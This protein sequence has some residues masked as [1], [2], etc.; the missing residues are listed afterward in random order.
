MKRLL[1]L[2]SVLFFINYD[3]FAQLPAITGTPIA[4]AGSTSALSNGTPG[5]VWTS[6]TPAIATVNMFTGVVTGVS[7]GTTTITYTVGVSNVTTTFLVNPLPA[8]ITGVTTVC[9][10]DWTSLASPGG[11]LWTSSNPAVA[12][13]GSLSGRVTSTAAG[14]TNI[15]Y[16][17]STGCTT[18]VPVTVNPLPAPIG[19]NNIVYT[20]LTLLLSDATAGGTWSSELPS[21][22]TVHPT[23]GLVTGA[24]P[25]GVVSI[26]YTLPTGCRATKR[27]NVN[28]LPST[29]PLGGL[30]GWYPFCNDTT[31][32]SGNTRH[33]LNSNPSTIPATPTTDRFGI[34]NSAFEFNGINTMMNYTTFFPNSGITGDFSYSCWINAYSNQSSVIIYNGRN[35]VNGFGF[36]MNNGTIGT[37]GSNV[38]VIFGGIAQ[39]LSTPITL[40]QWHNLVL[41]KTGNTYNFYIDNVSAGFFISAFIP[42]TTVF[43]VGMDYNTIADPFV[44]K[45]D[46]I[47]IYDRQI[48]TIERTAL[49]TFNP[50]A[51]PFSLGNDTTICADS[52]TIAPTPMTIAR[53]YTWSNGNTV[54]HSITVFPAAG[55]AGNN[56]W[57]TV[58]RQFACA[59]SDTIHVVKTPVAVN[60]GIDTNICAGDTITLNGAPGLAHIWST[61]D[62]SATIR[63]YNTGLYSVISDSGVCVGRDTIYVHKSRVPNP[64]LGPDIASCKG[65]PVILTPAFDAG[66]TYLWNTS[67]TTASLLVNTTGS[68]WVQ[69]TDTGC[70]RSDSIN[71]LIVFDTVTLFSPDTVICKGATVKPRV[72]VN[73][74]ISYQWTPTAGIPLATMP[75][76]AITPDTSSWYVL[77]TRYPG[78]PDN[79]DS[80]YID[81]QPNPI[82]SVGMNRHVCKFDT[83]HLFASVSPADYDLYT[84]SWSPGISL[85]DSEKQAVV[86]TAGDT[87]NIIV[88]VSTPGGCVG[89]DSTLLYV[90]PANYDSLI[91]P[92]HHLCPG[93]SV[94]LMPYI[95]DSGNMQ[96]VIIAAS[97]W[98]PGIY[99]DDSTA[100]S[101]WVHPITTQSYTLISTTQWGCH[102]TSYASIVVHPDAVVYLG[103]SVTIFTGESYEIPTQ[104]NCTYFSWT[105]QVA[106]SDTLVANPIVTPYVN[107]KYYVKATTDWGCTTTDSIVIRVKSITE[108]AMPN[109]FTPGTS[110]NN[111]FSVIKFGLASINY[112]R[113]YDRWGVKVFETTNINEGWDGTYNNKPQ[114]FGVY[115]YEVDATTN[116]GAGITR[117]GN[118]TLIR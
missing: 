30:M 92:P 74:I 27:V 32:H 82:V 45:I 94:Q 66:H 9:A 61:G 26:Y 91:L 107:T 83:L 59:A 76:P 116:R 55:I 58:S 53:D 108:I 7:A 41:I 5:G 65:T 51:Q 22:A 118:V 69:V 78:C 11:G 8:P 117:R 111:V 105:P 1:L 110:I 46:D 71:V 15:T 73:A 43:Q 19:G 72:T 103:D 42:M 48:T 89:T 3:L 18:S 95:N 38:A 70:T 114:P 88:T 17:L 39:Y 77:T 62:T 6:S 80:F 37:P 52:I 64:S 87:T 44:G 20:G 54:D 10:G 36:V 68:Y 57:L 104:T 97:N 47:A 21:Y 84:F 96:G 79:H 49:N 34:P 2:L 50:Y 90:H 31:D 56:Y 33:L 99:L 109:A 14:F 85:D 63:V 29:S 40:N 60:L 101:P 81:V 25:S 35:N 23:S 16:T 98:T 93:D 12:T 75:S 67:A 28:P 112:F 100:R 24:A 4:C 106:I 13:V 115:V 102:D 113:I 86:F